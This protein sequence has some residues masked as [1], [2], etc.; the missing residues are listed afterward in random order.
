MSCVPAGERE[1]GLTGIFAAAAAL[2]PVKDVA[3]IPYTN[4]KATGNNTPVTMLAH[5][6]KL[7]LLPCV[8]V[9]RHTP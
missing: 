2:L 1:A 6:V 3:S 4:M 8:T 9:S 5:V 7:L